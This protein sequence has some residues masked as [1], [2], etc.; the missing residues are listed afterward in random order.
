MTGQRNP[1]HAALVSFFLSFVPFLSWAG[2]PEI[3]LPEPFA[4]ELPPHT[5]TLGAD[6][7]PVRRLLAATRAEGYRVTMTLQ[8]ERVGVGV[9][10]AILSAWGPSGDRP[11]ARRVA[12]LFVFPHGIVPIGPTGDENASGGNNA[13]HIVHDTDGFVHMVWT[14]AWSSGAEGGFYRRGKVLPDGTAVLDTDITELA[15]H[16]GDWRSLPALAS[17]GNTVHFTWQVEGT[18]YYRSLTHEGGNW[19]WSREVDTR[20][21]SPG[22]DV[23]PSIVADTKGVYILT[24]AGVYT[25]SRDGGQTWTTETV[26]FGSPL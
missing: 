26:P 1:L 9:W 11:A 17:V 20:A 6:D 15:P 18:A 2:T 5:E 23:G 24:P 4:V 21:D 10:R 16:K 19:R 8:R 3:L 12:Y 13:F 14:N 22:R 7:A 25:E